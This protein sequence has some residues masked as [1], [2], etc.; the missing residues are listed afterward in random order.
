VN[1]FARVALC[2][3]IAGYNGEDIALQNVRALLVMRVKLQGFIV[4]DRMDLWPPALAELGKA[5]ATGTIK[6]RE[7][8][9]EGLEAAPGA[10]IGLLKGENF[11]KQ[12]VK[13]S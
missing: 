11:G 12:L 10:F 13:L 3:L 9:A 5:V 8:I 1:P 2:G 7:T 6:Y 4:S